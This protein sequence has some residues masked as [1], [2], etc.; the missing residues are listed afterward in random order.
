MKRK[1][2]DQSLINQILKDKIDIK[3]CFFFK[4]NVIGFNQITKQ[5]LNENAK[6]YRKKN[7]KNV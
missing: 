3:S 7:K 5:K 2:E 1:Q 4:K 6:P